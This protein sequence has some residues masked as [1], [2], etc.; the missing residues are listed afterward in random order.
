MGFILLEVVLITPSTD[1]L[2][3]VFY[4]FY[5]KSIFQGL[6]TLH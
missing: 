1:Y 3:L 2:T 4:N 5:C 6:L